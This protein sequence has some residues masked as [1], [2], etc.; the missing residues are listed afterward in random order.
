MFSPKMFTSS[1]VGLG[2]LKECTLLLKI[3]TKED[4]IIPRCDYVVKLAHMRSQNI[5]GSLK[6]GKLI[7][8]YSTTIHTARNRCAAPR[9]YNGNL[10]HSISRLMVSLLPAE[11][12]STPG[13]VTFSIGLPGL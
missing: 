12:Y 3:I 6:C 4:I 8:K 7:R 1:R 10:S 2:K 9:I 13:L 5:S 11:G